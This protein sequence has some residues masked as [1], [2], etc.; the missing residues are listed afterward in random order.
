MRKNEFCRKHE[1]QEVSISAEATGEFDGKES[2]WL[3]REYETEIKSCATCF[4]WCE[5]H[6]QKEVGDE[7]LI[8]R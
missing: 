1:V 3:D 4:E 5:W 6:L 7:K 2:A 8:R